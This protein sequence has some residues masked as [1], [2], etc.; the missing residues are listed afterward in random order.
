[1]IIL[2]NKTSKQW[3]QNNRSDIL[4][5]MWASFGLNL[6]EQLGKVKL[7]P[8]MVITTIIPALAVAFKNSFGNLYAICTAG[9]Y[10]AIGGLLET[11]MTADSSVNFPLSDISSLYSD[12][13]TFNSNLVITGQYGA[14]YRKEAGTTWFPAL[15][16]ANLGDGTTNWTVTNPSG[17]ILHFAYISG[18]DPSIGGTNIVSNGMLVAIANGGLTGFTQGN[19]II[20]GF[21]SDYLEITIVGASGFTGTYIGSIGAAISAKEGVQQQGS[22]QFHKLLNFQKTQRLYFFDAFLQVCSCDAN[23]NMASQNNT[24]SFYIPNFD[25][26]MTSMVANDQY[27]FILTMSYYNATGYIFIW[28]GITANTPTSIITLESR[29]A[30]AGINLNGTIY[31]MDTNG[32]LMYHN[33]T[34]FVLAKNGQLPVKL[35][36]YLNI[37]SNLAGTNKWL[38]P[39][40]MTLV[41]GRINM[42]INNQNN[43]NAGT[44]QEALPSGVWEYDA[45]MGWYHKTPLTLYQANAVSPVISD[46]GQNRVAGV[47]ALVCNKPFDTSSNSI[48]GTLIGSATLYTTSTTTESAVLTD[49]SLDTIQKRGYLTTVKILSSSIQD[50]FSQLWLRIRP[51]LNSTDRIYVKYRTNDDVATEVSI[52]WINNNSFTTTGNIGNYVQGNEVEILNGTGSGWTPNIASIT[53]NSPSPGTYTIV[54]D[55]S[56]TGSQMALMGTSKAR[57]QTWKNA[58]VTFT[59]QKLNLAS[60]SIFMASSPW[61]QL[62]ICFLF[63]GNDEMVDAI[64][65]NNPFQQK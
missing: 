47:G 41:N 13:E 29:G 8:R 59:T 45:D 63:T 24:Y 60:F 32:R 52:T 39:N 22:Q 16:L 58:G 6:T 30:L 1:M 26:Q 4:G 57:F 50:A 43:D 28:D 18:T 55:E 54:L 42:L 7:S 64:L 48:I 5:T 33:G 25:L 27:I 23:Y 9:I 19:Y 31:I 17:N 20:T 65:I 37:N 61:V 14:M 34:T 53:P 10:Y 40:G 15:N 49:D 56:W 11:Q 2:P 12:M 62:K 44:I 38:H 21:G 3:T 36:K 51:L 46:Y 35:L